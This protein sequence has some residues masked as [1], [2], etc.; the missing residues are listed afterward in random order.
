MKTILFFL[1]FCSNIWSIEDGILKLDQKVKPAMI[2]SDFPGAVTV[3]YAIDSIKDI[4]AT[5]PLSE[6]SSYESTEHEVSDSSVV[7]PK[8]IWALDLSGTYL[9]AGDFSTFM[10]EMESEFTHLAV[11][12]LSTV[13][14]KMSSWDYIFHYIERDT[15]KYVDVGGTSYASRGIIDVLKKGMAIYSN[16]WENLSLKLIF[17]DR[18]YYTR[19]RDTMDWYKPYVEGKLLHHQWYETH[20]RYFET[21]YTAIKN[22]KPIHLLTGDSDDESD[23]EGSFD[24]DDVEFDG[25]PL[26]NGKEDKY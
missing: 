23:L 4:I 6:R 12:I 10:T 24:N 11:L 25:L 2:L 13:S 9:S 16:E 1:L 5:P 17:S 7:I 8:P 19:L 3:R 20:S 18:T 26:A 22:A 15:F 21:D 14:L